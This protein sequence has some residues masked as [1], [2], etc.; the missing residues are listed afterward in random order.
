[1]YSLIAKRPYAK[2][3]AKIKIL[4]PPGGFVL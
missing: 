1:L 3:Y 4:K 2:P